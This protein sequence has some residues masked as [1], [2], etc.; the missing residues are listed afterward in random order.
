MRPALSLHRARGASV[1]NGGWPVRRCACWTRRR[2]PTRSH[3]PARVSVQRRASS[4]DPRGHCRSGVPPPDRGEPRIST[5]GNYRQTGGRSLDP[6]ALPVVRGTRLRAEAGDIPL[7]P[8]VGWGGATNLREPDRVDRPGTREHAAGSDS[9][10]VRC[11]NSRLR[12]IAPSRIRIAAP[13]QNCSN[14]RVT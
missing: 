10:I 7:E 14:S 12:H 9:S 3:A 13:A 6:E 5:A 4:R 11:E 1:V 8:R 2:S